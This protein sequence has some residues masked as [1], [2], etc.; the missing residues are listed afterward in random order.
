ML[1]RN[2]VR[3]HQKAHGLKA[4]FA[5][6][7][8]VLDRH[9]G[10]GAVGGDPADRPAVTLGLNDVFLGAHPRQHQEGDLRV[11]GGVGGE[12]DEL[13][14]GSLA[15]AVVERRSAKAVTVRDLDDRHAGRVQGRDDRVHLVAGELMAL[16][17]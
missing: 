3:H 15:E 16:V 6:E 11:L 4:P 17:V 13:L 10:L 8:E 12:F 1:R 2:G 14:L 7:P 9:V 5:G